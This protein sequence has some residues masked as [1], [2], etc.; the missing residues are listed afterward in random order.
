VYHLERTILEIV[1]GHLEILDKGFGFLRRIEDNLRST[2]SDTFVPAQ[3][4][5]QYK[6][7]EGIYVEGAGVKG[8][9]KQSNLKLSRIDAINGR[10]LKA[11]A[12]TLP[13]Q[14]QTSINPTQRFVVT[15]D[16]KDLMGKALDRIVPVGRGQRGLIIAP[17]KTGKTTI[18]QH[19]ANAI[20]ERYADA[21]VFVL[22]VDERPEEVT[23]FRRGVKNAHV[24][25]SSADQS[26]AQHIRM[27]RLSIH[28][29]IRCA[30]AGQDAV[31]FIDSLTR[32]A[33]AFNT[34]TKSYGRTMSGGLAANALDIPRQ[35]F[36]AARKIEDGGSLTIVATILVETG[37]RMD[38]II[39]QEF[40]GTGNMDLVLNRDCAEQR[41]WPAIDIKQSG[42]RK[43]ELLMD[44]T[45]YQESIEMRRS[46]ASLK[47]VDALGALLEH[48]NRKSS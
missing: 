6:L 34:E 45:Q 10:P 16:D 35:V 40:K 29:A 3:L 7:R 38:D 2:S 27:T 30:E 46:L 33:R 5:N 20:T 24:L 47:P 23:D 26:I 9:A 21:T 32:M 18:L 15:R 28:C 4:I 41:L 43:E 12:G 44:A 48:L 8:G 14:Q 39:Y 17:P 37:S 1:T 11:Y 36:G 13:L 19:M 42:T 31:V 25:A 22:L